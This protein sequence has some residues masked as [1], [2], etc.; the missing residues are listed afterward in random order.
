MRENYLKIDKDFRKGR[1]VGFVNGKYDCNFN[2][3]NINILDEKI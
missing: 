3:K 2:Y 1:E